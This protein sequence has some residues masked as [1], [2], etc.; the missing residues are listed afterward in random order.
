MGKVVT[1]E[2][3]F[4]VLKSYEERLAR[5]ERALYVLTMDQSGGPMAAPP[6]PEENP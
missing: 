5:L 3:L 2:D 6:P 1:Q 4:D